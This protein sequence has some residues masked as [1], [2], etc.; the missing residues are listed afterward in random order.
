MGYEQSS[1][2]HD[3]RK[4]ILS[5]EVKKGTVLFFNDFGSCPQNHKGVDPN[6]W[7]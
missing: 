5:E 3:E 1:F 7:K 4:I 6:E 2:E